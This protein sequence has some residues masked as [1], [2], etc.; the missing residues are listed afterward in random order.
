MSNQYAYNILNNETPLGGAEYP[1]LA[2]LGLNWSLITQSVKQP[3]PHAAT[4]A[5]FQQIQPTLRWVSDNSLHDLFV[6][7]MNTAEFLRATGLVL[8]MGQGGYV[9]SKRLSRI[10]R[11]YFIYGFF[12]P[13]QITVEYLNLDAH[14]QKVWDGAGRIRRSLLVRLIDQLPANLTPAKRR[15]MVWELKHAQRVEFTLMTERGQ[16][17]GHAIVMEDLPADLVLPPDTKPQIE[18]VNGQ[19]FI[20]LTPVH[21]ADEMRL[22]IQSL[23]N[24]YPFFDVPQLTQW[25]DEEGKLFTL[26][27]QSGA[28]GDAMSRLDPDGS[29]ADIERWHLHE[30]FVSGGHT[31]WFG[32][33]VRGLMNQHLKRLGNATLGKLRLPVPGGRYYVMTDAVGNRSIPRGEMCLEPTSGTAWVNAEDWCDHI[34][35]VLGGADQDDALWIFPFTDYDGEQKLLAW[36][37]PN[38]C[39]EYVIFRPSADSH[40]LT[41]ATVSDPITYPSADSRLL[42]PRIDTATVD[43]L[44]LVDEATAG[45]LGEGEIYN[46]EGMHATLERAQNNQGVLGQYCNALMLAKALYHDLPNNPPASLEMVIDG[47]VKTGVDLGPVRAWCFGFSAQIVKQRIPIPAILQNRLSLPNRRTSLLTSIDHWLD[48]LVAVIQSHIQDFTAER[49]RLIGETMP[50]V[51]IFDHAMSQPDSLKIASDFIRQYNRILAQ[52][53]VSNEDW[54]AH[55]QAAEASMALLARYTLEERHGILLAVLA[56][57]YLGESVGRDGAA[58]QMGSEDELPMARMTLQALRSIGLLDE[59]DQMEQGGLLRYPAAHILE[60]PLC[61]IGINGVWFNWLRVWLSAQGQALPSSM[62]DVPKSQ[63]EWAK[64]KIAHLAQTQFRDFGLHIRDENGRK[65]AYTVH[66]NLFGYLSRD[67][68][69][70]VAQGDQL[71]IQAA[72]AQDGNLRVVVR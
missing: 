70:R 18:L 66:G 7:G 5:T 60:T 25:L 3:Q 49:E 37:S 45:G 27:V 40:S 71:N 13:Q 8:D 48:R 63:A 1:F 32:S 43:Y 38:Q 35:A 14:G 56:H 72:I 30:Y 61:S 28:V 9:L 21:S 24:F 57:S 65:V 19:V 6:E 22:D 2:Q 54:A 12:K 39:G 20:G 55:E 34:A 41:W 58:W 53:R 64:N 10:M 68:A 31:M 69:G 51:E 15:Q 29:L 33:M 36:R 11:S 47:S 52:G 42:M 23:I 67:S 46:I 17:K 16:D 62:A 44:N 26:A 4:S 59:I 50:P